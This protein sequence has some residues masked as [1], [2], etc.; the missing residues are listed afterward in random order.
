MYTEELTLI[1]IIYKDQNSLKRLI[2]ST[3]QKMSIM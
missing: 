3:F 1:Y 2:I